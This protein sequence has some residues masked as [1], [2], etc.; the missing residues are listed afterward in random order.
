VRFFTETNPGH[1][2]GDE[3]A[4]LVPLELGNLRPCGR[5]LAG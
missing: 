4:C 3:L 1:R 5:R 2:R